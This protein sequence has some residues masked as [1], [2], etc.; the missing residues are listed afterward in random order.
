MGTV[1]HQLFNHF[2]N[3]EN[4]I[5]FI[6][7][8]WNQVRQ[9]NENIF[10]FHI[11]KHRLDMYSAKCSDIF[12]TQKFLRWFLFNYS[13]NSFAH[14]NATGCTWIAIAFLVIIRYLTFGCENI[15]HLLF[16]SMFVVV[17]V[18]KI[19]KSFT[20]WKL[21]SRMFMSLSHIS[22]L[23][24]NTI[25]NVHLSSNK[26]LR[27]RYDLDTC[28]CIVRMELEVICFWKYLCREN[29]IVSD[30]VSERQRRKN[31]T[32][33]KQ[34]RTQQI[35]IREKKKETKWDWNEKELYL[36]RNGLYASISA[37]KQ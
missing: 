35:H 11:Y 3:S 4:E 19:P 10:L 34:Q 1:E 33:W 36:E 6:S 9:Y 7:V 12:F 32:V 28:V 15:F 16:Y 21:F 23:F 5:L 14:P 29:A 37:A 24:S 13:M 2:E 22:W 26:W 25:P 17:R 27:M 31:S 18:G 8:I 30:R 20:E